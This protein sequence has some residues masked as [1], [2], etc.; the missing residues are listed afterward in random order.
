[1]TSWRAA[2]AAIW[3]MSFFTGRELRV[4]DGPSSIAASAAEITGSPLP[5]EAGPDAPQVEPDA[6][7]GEDPRTD[8][9]GN[10]VEDAV[11]DYRI[12]VRGTIYE[13][14]SPETAVRQLASPTT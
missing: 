6:S 4:P 13:R 12:D 11:A 3:L 8:L 14:H 5:G 2:V 9:S 10:E 1:M 7:D